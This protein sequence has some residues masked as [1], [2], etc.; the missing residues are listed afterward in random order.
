MKLIIS[1]DKKDAIKKTAAIISELIKNKP[2]AVLGLATGSTMIP[3]YKELVRLYKKGEINFYDVRTFNFD[4]YANIPFNDKESYHY[5]MN[6]NLF[7][8]VNIQKHQTYFPSSNGE[9]YEKEIKNAGGID[10]SILGIG[11]NGHIAFNEPGS[12]FESGTREVRLSESTLNANSRLFPVIKKTPREA[13]TVGIKTI[14]KSKR[15]ILLAFGEKKAD[16]ISKTINGSINEKTPASIL[17]KHKNST[18]IVDK[19]AAKGL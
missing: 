8:K 3:L 9:E 13:Y 7:N 16:A 1:N 17:R 15:I 6:K 2:N 18:F 12:S 19:K 14:M 11:E 5:Y 10:L 4:E